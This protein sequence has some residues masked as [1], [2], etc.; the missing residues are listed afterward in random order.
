MVQL[1]LTFIDEFHNPNRMYYYLEYPRKFPKEEFFD[2]LNHFFR[3][4]YFPEQKNIESNL[5]ELNV[6]LFYNKAYYQ[7]L[8]L[9]P[10]N[11]ENISELDPELTEGSIYLGNNPSTY[12][13]I[14]FHETKV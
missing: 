11:L 2:V 7:S 12:I 3:L 14:K 9:D 8:A 10:S 5:D 1:E 6:L 4:P 13:K